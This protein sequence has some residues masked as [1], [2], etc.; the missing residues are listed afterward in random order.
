MNSVSEFAAAVGTELGST[1]LV[2]AKHIHTHEYPKI[3]C[4]AAEGET[5][6]VRKAGNSLDSAK[7][8]K[9]IAERNLIL[10][11]HCWQ[12]TFDDAEDLAKNVYIAAR[13]V[14]RANDLLCT[15]H[16]EQWP[17]QSE[18]MITAAGEYVIV[19]IEVGFALIDDSQTP[20]I[21]PRRVDH[22]GR[23]LPGTDGFDDGFN[24]GYQEN[25][26]VC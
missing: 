26:D 24:Y 6:P 13:R 2:G 8:E 7:W 16:G 4:V 22:V 23:F 21:K 11:F 12:L 14:A 17:I 10:Q 3:V 15:L 5:S 9:T 1:I 20:L 19:R 25:E 18:E